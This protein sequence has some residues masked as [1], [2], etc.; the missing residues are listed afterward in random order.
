VIGVLVSGEEFGMARCDIHLLGSRSGYTTIAAS[1]GV[2]ADERRELEQLHFGEVGTRGAAARLRHEPAM[3][4]F[5]LRSGRFAISRML[6]SDAL[7]DAGRPTVEVVTL[8]LEGAA[9]ARV[10]GVLP[11]LADEIDWWDRARSGIEN[12][13]EL[14]ELAGGGSPQDPGMRAIL[15]LWI[16][17]RASQGGAAGLLP[18]SEAAR[19]LAFV[20]T[21]DAADRPLLR[22]GLGMRTV[23]HRVDLCAL[24]PEG[25]THGMRAVIRLAPIDAPH[26]PRET[27]YATLRATAGT[28][29]FVRI[30]EISAVAGDAL[31]GDSSE[32]AVAERLPRSAR[33]PRGPM[34]NARL[35]AIG[36]SVLSTCVLIV[37]IVLH[38]DR[39]M[40]GTIGSR[41]SSEASSESAPEAPDPSGPSR[42]SASGF[43]VAPPNAPPTSDS[44]PAS[45]GSDEAASTPP[46]EAAARPEA[47]KPSASTPPSGAPAAPSAPVNVPEASAGEKGTQAKEVDTGPGTGGASSTGPGEAPDAGGDGN[48]PPQPSAVQVPQQSPVAVDRA[49]SM[50]EELRERLQ[51]LLD[52]MPTVEDPGSWVPEAEAAANHW[53]IEQVMAKADR[54]HHDWNSYGSKRPN[55][56][57]F[58]REARNLASKE[59][60]RERYAVSSSLREVLPPVVKSFNECL[61]ESESRRAKPA[62]LL[63]DELTG[64]QQTFSTVAQLWSGLSFMLPA[65][66]GKGDYVV[67]E[68]KGGE[69]SPAAVEVWNECVALFLQAAVKFNKCG[70]SEE[71][72]ESIASDVWGETRYPNLLL[73]DEAKRVRDRTR[74]WLDDLLKRFPKEKAS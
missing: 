54:D 47:Q 21:L 14:P 64:E 11:R 73:N 63:S 29:H 71:Q 12:G 13:V 62:T 19:L 25:S 50:L 56:S 68:L 53:V 67:P 1:A 31:G 42:E 34:S 2:S 52:R 59:K 15:D 18:I 8:V 69:L 22:W 66:R 5:P 36:A 55:R 41:A 28:P 4:G 57:H 26:R 10:A 39:P 35:S 46:R 33:T 70:L 49:I 40:A 38:R 37:A 65:E 45:G 7:D 30:A 44:P 74:K 72:R 20:A 32:P 23:S 43:G 27:E 9:Y 60:W 24:A 16:A 61:R 17:V 6:P 51:E 3:A 58:E 48:A